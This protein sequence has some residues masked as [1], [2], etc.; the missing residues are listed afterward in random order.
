MD[1]HRAVEIYRRII[2]EERLK[3]MKRDLFK[4][5]KETV[6]QADANDPIWHM[7]YLW[8]ELT[9][10]QCNVLAKDVL[11][12]HPHVQTTIDLREHVY[13]YTLP[14]GLVLTVEPTE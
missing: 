5:F 10:R 14:N 13:R 8:L 4:R 1:K 2:K 9:D 6:K 7:G 3:D 11:A 12:T